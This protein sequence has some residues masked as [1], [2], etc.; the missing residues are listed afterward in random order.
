MIGYHPPV[1]RAADKKSRVVAEKAVEDSSSVGRQ[2]G[3]KKQNGEGGTGTEE[4]R[5]MRESRCLLAGGFVAVYF[6]LPE[7]PR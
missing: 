1:V 6:V 7:I 2:V 3:E 5:R 4:E